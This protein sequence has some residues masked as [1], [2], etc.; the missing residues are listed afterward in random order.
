MNCL[1]TPCDKLCALPVLDMIIP[2]W[3]ASAKIRQEHSAPAHLRRVKTEFLILRSIRLARR[4]R[5]AT[6]GLSHAGREGIE[7]TAAGNA[8]TEIYR[9]NHG[10]TSQ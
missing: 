1:S 3:S 4:T 10:R 9:V 2:V 7:R 6:G 5:R 8:I